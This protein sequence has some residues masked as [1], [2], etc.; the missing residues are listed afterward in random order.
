METPTQTHTDRQTAPRTDAINNIIN[1]NGSV[2]SSLGAVAD[3]RQLRCQWLFKMGGNALPKHLRLHLC[4][5]VCVCVCFVGIWVG[6]R[7]ADS[8]G[9]RLPA[10]GA[11]TQRQAMRRRLFTV[12]LLLAHSLLLHFYTLS[13]SLSLC[14]FSCSRQIPRNLIYIFYLIFLNI[15]LAVY[16]HQSVTK[17]HASTNKAPADTVASW[18]YLPLASPFPPSP[19]WVVLLATIWAHQP[20]Q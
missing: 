20:W 3:G 2:N 17:T 15:S 11:Y 7:R 19:S 8:C 6:S 18:G 10:T 13:P 16:V 12:F 5:Y 14:F 1:G 9:I 4:A